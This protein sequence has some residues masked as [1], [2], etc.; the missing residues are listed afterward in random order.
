MKIKF[1]NIII[2]AILSS[3][4]FLSTRE[5]ESPDTGSLSFIPPTSPSIVVQNLITSIKEKNPNNYVSCFLDSMSGDKRNM[6]FIPLSSVKAAYPELFNKWNLQSERNYFMLLISKSNLEKGVN[7]ELT[8]Q[9]F[10][11]FAIDSVVY[12]ADYLY[13]FVLSSTGLL[14]KYSGSLRFVFTSK[15]N[16]Y[17]GISTWQDFSIP[18][19]SIKKTWSD[20]KAEFSY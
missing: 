8:N 10:E 18:N 2:L 9:K 20:L 1:R 4:S 6:N 13:S 14:N 7:V 15:S 19:D 11:N 3:C 16:G 12:N 17:W 5:P